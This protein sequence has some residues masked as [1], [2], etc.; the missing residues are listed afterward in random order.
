MDTSLAQAVVEANIEQMIVD[1]NVQEWNL[2]ITYERLDGD[3]IASV[4]MLADYK[5]ATI[6]IDPAK[7]E[8]GSEVLRSLRHEL[9]HLHLAPY[10]LAEETIYQLLSEKERRVLSRMMTAACEQAIRNLEGMLEH[11]FG[12]VGPAPKPKLKV[13]TGKD[14]KRRKK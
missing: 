3:T 7:H 8:E 1:L 11:G 14:S 10:E 4:H 2:R 6:T 5:K 13:V 9:L 12:Y